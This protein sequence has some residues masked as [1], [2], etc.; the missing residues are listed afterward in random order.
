[1]FGMTNIKIIDATFSHCCHLKWRF[2][3][4]VAGEDAWDK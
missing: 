3:M 2:A 4:S 1:M